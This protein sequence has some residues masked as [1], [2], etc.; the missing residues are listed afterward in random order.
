MHKLARVISPHV[1]SSTTHR[2]KFTVVH[3]NY[4]ITRNCTLQYDSHRLDQR[5]GQ[6]TPIASACLFISSR[7]RISTLDLTP[8]MLAYIFLEESTLPDHRCYVMWV[9]SER[10]VRS[11]DTT[12][13]F[14]HHPLWGTIQIGCKACVHREHYGESLYVW[15]P[16]CHRHIH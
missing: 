5:H 12:H 2:S 9:M 3:K 6:I 8:S 1:N 4:I 16:L 15:K 11:T 14:N 13:Q 10:V 7:S